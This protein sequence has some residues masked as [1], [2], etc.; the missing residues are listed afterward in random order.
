MNVYKFSPSEYF[1]SGDLSYD[2]YVL[3]ISA[4]SIKAATLDAKPTNSKFVG[5]FD[6]DEKGWRFSPEFEG[7]E[8]KSKIEL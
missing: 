7:G 8:Q 1:L 6:R 4:P 5:C 2:R 3:D